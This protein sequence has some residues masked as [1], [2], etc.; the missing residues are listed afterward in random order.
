MARVTPGARGTGHAVFVVAV[1]AFQVWFAVDT[2][3]ASARVENLMLVLPLTGVA[4]LLGGVILLGIVR[5]SATPAPDDVPRP[6]DPRIP[7]LMLALCAYLGGLLAVGFDL[8]TFLFL[9]VSI[10]LLGERNLWAILIFSVAV[11]G[12]C[13]F[14]L[15]AM[16]SVPVPTLLF[17]GG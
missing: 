2:W 13:V 8:P 4:L 15:R 7:L 12:F 17:P 11:T 14:G 16:V 9:A 6:I 3:R 5:S 10:W 1:L